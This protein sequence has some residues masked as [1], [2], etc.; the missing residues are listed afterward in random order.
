MH[1]QVHSQVHPPHVNSKIEEAAMH[2]Q[3]RFLLQSAI[4]RIWHQ[5]DINK[6]NSIDAKEAKQMIIDFCSS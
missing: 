4:E 3:E 2:P 1:Q 6:S 5:Y